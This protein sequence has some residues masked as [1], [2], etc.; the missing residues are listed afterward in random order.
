MKVL[1]SFVCINGVLAVVCCVECQ[2]VSMFMWTPNI[3]SC[4]FIEL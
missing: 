2:F 4:V 3:M 1:C